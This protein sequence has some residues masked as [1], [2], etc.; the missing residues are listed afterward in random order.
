AEHVQCSFE[1]KDVITSSL[2]LSSTGRC[3]PEMVTDCICP[4]MCSESDRC[5]PL[6]DQGERDAR[7][8]G[9]ATSGDRPGGGSH[10]SD[11]SARRRRSDRSR[12]GR[13]S[14]RPTPAHRG[15][16]GR[17]GGDRRH[18]AGRRGGAEG[19]HRRGFG[20]LALGG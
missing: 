1:D 2:S 7:G 8:E 3:H 10:G 15:T 4:L 18:A 16:P 17:G 14:A 5:S 13:T 9:V 11:G 19:G 20:L 6:I 12:G